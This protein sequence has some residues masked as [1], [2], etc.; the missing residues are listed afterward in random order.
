[1]NLEAGQ[2]GR[3]GMG[4]EM[5]SED[6]AVKQLKQPALIRP[7]LLW[8]PHSLTVTA[9]KNQ[10]A[11]AQARASSLGHATPPASCQMPLHPPGPGLGPL[12]CTT[13]TQLLRAQGR[14]AAGILT[15]QRRACPGGACCN[16]QAWDAE[17]HLPASPTGSAVAGQPPPQRCRNPKSC[18]AIHLFGNWDPR[19]P[20]LN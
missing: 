16:A 10:T 6:T 8:F 20:G 17:R 2:E 9:I 5:Q 13:F 12:P 3:A 19:E 18:V 7:V 1:M 4:V 14:G 15:R 11:A